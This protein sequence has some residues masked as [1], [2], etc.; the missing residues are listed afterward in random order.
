MHDPTTSRRSFL[1]ATSAASLG[2]LGLYQFVNHPLLAAPAAPSV[3]Y[4]ELQKDPQG[5]LNLPKGFSYRI[6]SRHG[7]RMDDGLVVPARP[8]GMA[9][10][11]GRGGRVILVRNHENGVNPEHSAF[12]KQNELLGKVD[13][14]KF[15]DYGKGVAPQLG[16][17]TT[18]VYNERTGQIEVQYLSLAGTARNCA[19]GR[20]PWGTWITCEENTERAGANDGKT[21]Q[22]HGYNFE[23][24]ASEKPFLADPL[25]L[26]AMGRFNHEAVC[27]DPRTKIVYQTE[28]RPDGLIYRFLPN[29]GGQLAKGGKLQALAVRGQK[30]LDTRNWERLT[31]PKLAVG[32][33]LAVE[34]IDLAEIEAPKDD[35]RYRGFE[36][37]AA[38]FAR[39]EGM[40]FGQ[41][42]LYFACTNGG[43]K[44]QGQVFRYRPS[45]HEGTPRERDAPGTLEI[46]A[47]P[48]NSDLMKSC[49]NLTV[50]PWGDVV[51]CED[52][53]HSFLVGI[54]PKGELYHL[55]ENVGFQSEMAGG[56]FSPS[57]KTFFVNIQEVGVTVAITGPWKTA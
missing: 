51:L 4:G 27:V 56:V 17:T 8:D 30:S 6:I 44:E 43:Q 57:G 28:D 16:G 36:Q 19:G 42:E 45:A 39:G 21:E 9:T 35:L 10:F 33:P 12:G 47:E 22:D 32:Q 29:R 24:R 50:A 37:G 34:W 15:Y 46:F 55:A 54:T 38:R 25:P 26:R 5:I 7:D 49:D 2:F 3:G 1:K 53:P 40:W 31:T 18:V 20:T 41:N 52:T 48:N 23:V 13:R 14:A 11:R